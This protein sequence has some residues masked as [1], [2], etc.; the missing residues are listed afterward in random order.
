[1]IELRPKGSPLVSATGVA[2]RFGR[3][4]KFGQRLLKQWLDEQQDGGQARVLKR[5]RVLYTTEAVL[6]AV[7][8]GGARDRAIN[9]RLLVLERDLEVAYARIAELERRIGRRR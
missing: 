4:R 8:P 6:D 2:R 5:G 7:L 3:G 9:R 1:M